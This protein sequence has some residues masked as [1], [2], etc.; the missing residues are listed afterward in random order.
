MSKLRLATHL[1]RTGDWLRQCRHDAQAQS[2]AARPNQPRNHSFWVPPEHRSP[3]QYKRTEALWL[4][5]GECVEASNS[6]TPLSSISYKYSHNP[7]KQ[8]RR[9]PKA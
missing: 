8:A 1:P 3:H 5:G 7:P 4:P 9:R 6:R 2:H